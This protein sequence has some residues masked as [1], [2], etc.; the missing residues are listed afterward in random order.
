M[1]EEDDAQ[2]TEDPTA[3]KLSKAKEKG[4]TAT[5]QEVKSLIVLIGGV[6]G[7][8]F[9]F[10]GMMKDV[11]LMS[12]N[13]IT[14]PDTI[15]I[16]PSSF[17]LMFAEITGNLVLVL[18]P[19]FL[20]LMVLAFF[21]NVGQ[22]GLIWAPDKITPKLNKISLLAGSKRM[23]SLRS[24]VEFLKGILKLIIVGVVSVALVLPLLDDI[25]ILPWF[26][27]MQSLDRLH[28]VALWI[29]A[30]TIG[31]MTAVAA[32]DFIYQKFAFT[33]QMRMS[34]Q[35]VKDEFKQ[36]EGDPQIKARI[37]KIRVERAQQ[38]MMA[39]VPEADVVVTN[40]T[41]FACALKYKMKDMAA[42]VLV[43]KG[44]DHVA[45]KIKEVAEENDIPV[46]ENA[47][48][49]RALFAAVEIDEEIPVEHYKAVAEVIGYVMRLKGELPPEQ[50]S[51]GPG[52]SPDG[53]GAGPVL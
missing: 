27:V 52:G 22:T 34:K 47:P 49:A 29:S 6:L 9:I 18:W 11:L 7:L 4:Q 30:G 42:P 17:R 20:L 10:P 1:A 14:M 48:L 16:T 38:R 13:Y 46:V 43:A 5:S 53:G 51:G 25:A 15:T 19:I 50:P 23:F 39:S 26:E 32:L 8:A 33:K 44:Q 12:R 31:V 35:E 41:H 3:K 2:K 45:F 36:S 24:V 28:E 40:P 21:A 37:R